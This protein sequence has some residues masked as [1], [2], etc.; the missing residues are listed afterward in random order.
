MCYCFTASI[1]DCL[2]NDMRGF[3]LRL[4]GLGSMKERE[5]EEAKRASHDRDAEVE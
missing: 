1:D 2:V 5:D 3:D 4:V